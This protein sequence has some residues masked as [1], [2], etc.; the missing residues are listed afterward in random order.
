MLPKI[1]FKKV[2]PFPKYYISVFITFGF[3]MSA[4][5]YLRMLDYRKIKVTAA[6][7]GAYE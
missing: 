5:H 2:K 7:S 6:S 4:L 3:G 1:R